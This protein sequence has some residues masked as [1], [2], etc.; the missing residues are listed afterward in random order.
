MSMPVTP[1]VAITVITYRRPALLGVLLESLHVQEFTDALVR[2]IVVD[3]DPE[4]SAQSV[5][6]AASGPLEV[7]YL[8]EPEPGIPAARQASVE[9]A[10][11]DDLIIFID[12]DER[13]PQGWLQRM[14]DMWRSSGADVV[15][16]P[17]RGILPP[18]SPSWARHSDVYTSVCKHQTGDELPHAYTNNTLVTRRVL[19]TVTPAFDNAFRF[20]GSSD[21]HFFQRVK[22]A[23]FRI[24][25]VDDA[26]VEEDVP[27]ER[28]SLKWLARRAFRSGAGDTISRQLISPGWK[29]RAL[30]G[31]LGLARFGNGI[32]LLI[33]GIVSP[34]HRIKG[35]RRVCSGIGTFAG[36]LGMNYDEYRRR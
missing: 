15:T 27:V 8:R 14:L 9:A 13:A 10:A 20:T 3:N 28:V 4:G 11:T 7:V 32:L 29:S 35:F 36:L 1:T 12:D 22:R 34:S 26:V 25:W 16:G 17:V 30:S 18:N 6:E 5:V 31:A 19:N 23:G 21:L 33:A 2:V 24:V